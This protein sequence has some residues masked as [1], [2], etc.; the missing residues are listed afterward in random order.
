VLVVRDGRVERRAV[1][2]GAAGDGTVTVTSGLTPGESV[3]IEGPPDL[4][5]GT[6]VKEK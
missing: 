3:V 5:D 6:A 4:T 1:A 2:T